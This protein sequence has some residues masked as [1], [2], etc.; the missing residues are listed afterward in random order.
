MKKNINHLAFLL[1][2]LLW[3]PAT[4]L[5]ANSCWNTEPDCCWRSVAGFEYGV[6]ISSNAGKSKTFPAL[7]STDEFYEYSPNHQSQTR[8]MWGGYLGI[9]WC[10]MPEWN[11]QFD[12]NYSQ[13]AP[14][15]VN[16][17]LTQGLD[18][19]SQDT[20]T[21]KHKITIRQLLV[22]AK[23]SYVICD[24][25]R[26]YFLFGLGSSFNKSYAFSTTVPPL[27]TLTRL[28][29][30]NTTA[31]FTYAVGAGLDFELADCLYLGV[32]Y[33]F[34]DFG[35]ASLGS[36]TIDGLPVSGTLSQSHFY[37]NQFLA[38]LTYLF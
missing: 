18:V 19:Q 34:N 13:S 26:P 32:G 2:L 27:L 11:L 16:G 35:K 25:F 3:I 31:G 22:E 6:V 28:Y 38:Q 21:Y 20:F 7:T 12:V 14:F 33:R 17:T 5:L 8:S 37:A 15:T 23:L 36:A 30:N 9:E 24:L 29:K 4:S 1:T 10:G